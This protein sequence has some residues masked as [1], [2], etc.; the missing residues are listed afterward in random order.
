MA[1]IIKEQLKEMNGQLNF[2]I[3]RNGVLYKCEMIKNLIVTQGRFNLA[4]LLGG[5]TGMH[6]THVGIGTG[7]DAAISTD[8]DLSNVI[9][10]PVSEVRVASGLMAPDK[11]TFDDT[12]IVQ[13]HFRIGL[14]TGNGMKIGEYGLFCADSTLFSR[15]VRDSVFEKTSIDAIEGYWQIQ[16]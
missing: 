10:V 6:V 12:R 13:F 16:F 14:E 4:K 2:R 11:T 5:Q 8:M 15:I 1:A 3:I 9:K 7:T